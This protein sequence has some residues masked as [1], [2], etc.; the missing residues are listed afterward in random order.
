MADSLK[1]AHLKGMQVDIGTGKMTE[2]TDILDGAAKDSPVMD[3]TNETVQYKTGAIPKN[4]LGGR[5]DPNG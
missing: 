5:N 2:D 3:E 1:T 4:D